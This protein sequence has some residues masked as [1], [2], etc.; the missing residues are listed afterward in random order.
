MLVPHDG[1]YNNQDQGLQNSIEGN[2]IHNLYPP[3]SGS[4]Y[5]NIL[6]HKYY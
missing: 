4:L 5:M 3:F 1:Y 6:Y 2:G